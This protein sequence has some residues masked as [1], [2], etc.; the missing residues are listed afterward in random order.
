MLQWGDFETKFDH[1]SH[2]LKNMEQ[3]VKSYELKSTLQEKKNQVDK[4]KVSRSRSNIYCMLCN[5]VIDTL[6]ILGV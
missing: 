3:Q 4:F 5:V 6:Y 1:C 2:W